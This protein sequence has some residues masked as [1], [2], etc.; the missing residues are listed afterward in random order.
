MVGARLGCNIGFTVL[1]LVD[2]KLCQGVC[3][4]P[5]RNFLWAFVFNACMLPLA[6]GVLHHQGALWVKGYGRYSST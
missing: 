2:L 5:R 4:V 3:D 6:A 1:E